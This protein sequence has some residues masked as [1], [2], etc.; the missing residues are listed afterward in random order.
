MTP[1]G[2][3]IK[4]HLMSVAVI[5]RPDL[6]GKLAVLGEAAGNEAVHESPLRDP[7]PFRCWIYPAKAGGKAIP[8]FKAL[9]SNQCANNCRYCALQRSRDTARFRLT[10][11]EM[12]RAFWDLYRRGLVRGA[13]LSSSIDIDPETSMAR[14]V[15]TAEILRYRYGYRG[16]LHLKIMPGASEDLAMRAVEL[17]D[18]VSLNL[19]A[20]N[21]QRLRSLCPE[22]DFGRMLEQIRK[23]GEMLRA[24]GGRARG[25]TTQFVVGAAGESD[26]EILEVVG[27][28]YRELGLERCYFEAFSPVRGTPLEGRPPGSPLRQRRLYE[29]S[30]L[31]RDYGFS[32]EEIPLDPE[33][34][35][36]L[37]IDPKL[38][39]AIRHP[40]FFPVEVNTAEPEE[41]L[42]VPGLGPKGV[43]KILRLRA[44]GR[45][46][47]E[48]LK[49]LRIALRRAAPFLTCDGKPFKGDQSKRLNQSR[50]NLAA[51]SLDSGSENL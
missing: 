29:A 38:A 30:F 3:V 41:L 7:L 13:F 26:R 49:G 21:P 36:P 2:G 17:A 44:Q 20:P 15:D 50:L 27:R 24:P 25:Q 37:G 34:N 23:V 32:P 19:E 47:W 45:V 9:I 51:L 46:R 4:S 22:K 48:D 35:L 8:L 12:A 5:R 18:R 40:E 28:L 16:Y 6:W 11:D 43:E 14:L 39:W 42:R 10:P 1:L 31:L 33:G